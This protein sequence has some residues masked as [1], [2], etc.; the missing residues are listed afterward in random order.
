M[1]KC[2]FFETQVKYWAFK[3]RV[4]KPI[5]KPDKRIT[6]YH[7][8]A[9]PQKNL[10]RYSVCHTETSTKEDLIHLALH[11]LGHFK[12]WS[13]NDMTQIEREYR[14]EKFALNVFKKHLPN[15]FKSALSNT[16]SV[17]DNPEY[18]LYKKPFTKLLKEFKYGF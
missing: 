2:K 7:A 17:V 1:N 18:P 10:I 4:A 5:V 11:E 15:L 12:T 14:A 9:C 3:L 8:Y 6:F 13:Y 16:K